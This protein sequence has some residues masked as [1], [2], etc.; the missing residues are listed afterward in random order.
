MESKTSIAR[1]MLNCNRTFEEMIKAGQYERVDRN[2]SAQNFPVR[3][4]FKKTIEIKLMHFNT[5]REVS[6]K[7]VLL[8]INEAG[9]RPARIEELLAF[10]ERC[11]KA[12]PYSVVA[13]GS[14][15][16]D[17][18]GNEHVPYIFWNGKTK[19]LFLTKIPLN[20]ADDF[21]FAALSK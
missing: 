12:A 14:V 9:C 18:Q 11:K 20:W 21:R 1:I 10:G 5:A 13:L 7:N 19:S 15:W 8:A 3:V 16:Q 17:D 4:R 6:T 2:I